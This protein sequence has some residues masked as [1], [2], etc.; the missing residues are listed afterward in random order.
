MMQLNSYDVGE[1]NYNMLDPLKILG[2]ATRKKHGVFTSK[3]FSGSDGSAIV[4]SSEVNEV[5]GRPVV[6]YH[7]ETQTRRGFVVTTSCSH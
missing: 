3:R 4:S 5:K 7:P 6:L 2:E 1:R